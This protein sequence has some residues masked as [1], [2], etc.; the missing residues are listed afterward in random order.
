MYNLPSYEWTLV[1]VVVMMMI[2]LSAFLFA[3]ISIFFIVCSPLSFFFLLL[4]VWNCLKFCCGNHSICRTLAVWLYD[5]EIT[6]S[7]LTQISLEQ[8]TLCVYFS[9]VVVV[10][11]GVHVK[12]RI[13]AIVGRLCNTNCMRFR[14]FI[15]LICLL[16]SVCM[17][18]C[19]RTG[20]YLVFIFLLRSTVLFFFSSSSDPRKNW[21][22]GWC[23][24]V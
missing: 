14:W 1:V 2:C 20:V 23:V 11:V 6:R 12:N 5:T 13:F 8:Y 3:Y 21:W 16:L 9:L 17:R 18:V 4:L 22:I 15:Y 10:V 7:R 19:W 24:C